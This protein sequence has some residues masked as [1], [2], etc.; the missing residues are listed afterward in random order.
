MLVQFFG[1]IAGAR[2]TK[3]AAIGTYISRVV[4]FGVQ[5]KEITCPLSNNIG[6]HASSARS[7]CSSRPNYVMVFAHPNSYLSS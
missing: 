1:K 5:Y 3:M 2:L 4:F 7:S 6:V